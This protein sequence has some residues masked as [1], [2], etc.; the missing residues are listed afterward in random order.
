MSAYL[1]PVAVEPSHTISIPPAIASAWPAFLF[2]SDPN[3]LAWGHSGLASATSDHRDS[4]HS[5]EQAWSRVVAAAGADA[6]ILSLA[7]PSDHGAGHAFLVGFDALRHAPART[8]GLLAAAR[9]VLERRS[10]AS[11]RQLVTMSIAHEPELAT[12]SDLDGFARAGIAS[13]KSPL[14]G[15]LR[16]LLF[17]RDGSLHGNGFDRRLL[18][19]SLPLMHTS[20]EA[21][22]Q[23]R[24][25]ERRSALFEG[26]LDTM[27]TA[28]V[29]LNDHCRILYRNAAANTMITDGK[30][31]IV[32]R[33]GE[34]RCKLPTAT[35]A[36]L[37]SVGEVVRRSLTSHEAPIVIRIT[38]EELLLGFVTSAMS[39]S[40]GQ[41]NRCAM[42]MIPPPRSGE[43]GRE[44][45]AALGLLPCEQRFL[46]AFLSTASLLEAATK[47]GVSE[48][49]ARTYLKRIR[50]KLGV[51]RQME[52][53]QLLGGLVP[54]LR[55]NGDALAMLG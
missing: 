12:L 28:I 43:L 16:V 32:T 10:A 42:L 2:D 25:C 45:M 31:L 26:L 19:S 41:A 1:E 44:V 49:T 35:K 9:T 15:M 7:Q 14:G 6:A 40:G 37:A 13:W 48:E 36:L 8:N 24:R 38:D 3:L 11:A 39:R 34:L 55:Q 33:E 46:R 52:L 27:S 47:A 17:Q 50:S 22:V 20:I 54:P 30:G 5:R 23:S 18:E 29:L 53:V 21:F 4:D 51:H